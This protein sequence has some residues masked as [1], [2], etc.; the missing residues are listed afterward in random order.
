MIIER[1]TCED[2]A[3]ILSHLTEFWG[4]ERTRALHHPMFVREF[5]DSAFVIKDLVQVVAYLFGFRAQTEQIGYV[6]LVGV[7][8]GHRRRGLARRLYQHFIQSVGQCGCRR[9][10][11]TTT[12]GN[13][14]SIAFH[15]SL[16]MS[17]TGELNADGIAVVRDYAGP[18]ED[19]VV[20]EMSIDE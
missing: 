8:E 17:T 5:G 12:P 11:A 1:C 9:L 7:R 15:A 14:D 16:G 19:R 2:Y 10:K 13:A 4:S 20:F 18:G 6:H 3:H